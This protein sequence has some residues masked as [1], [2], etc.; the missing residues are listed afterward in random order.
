MHRV[1]TCPLADADAPLRVHFVVHHHRDRAAGASGATLSL[2]AAL[3]GRG[4]TVSYY[5]HDDAYGSAIS[6]ELS[7]M[8]R[9]PWYVARHLARSSS[10]YDVIDATTG[11]AWLWALLGRRGGSHA[12]L[13]TR[14]HGLEHVTTEDLQRRARAREFTLSRRYPVY[15]GGYRLWEVRQ[16]LRHSDAQI[17]LNE[18]DREYAV[19]RLGVATETTTVL[20]NG[21][22]DLFLDLPP[23]RPAST[24]SP[25]ALAFIGSWISRKGV[26]AIVE[27]TTVLLARGVPFTLRFLGTG[28]ETSALRAKFSP[29]LADSITGTSRY[30][31][32][33]LPGLLD[34]AEVLLHPSWTEGFSL[35]LVEGM[36]CGLA[37][38]STR[39]GGAT[40]VVRDGETGV[41]LAN[42]SGAALADAVVRLADDRAHLARMRVAA[43]SSMQALRWDTIAAR[44]LEVYRATIARRSLHQGEAT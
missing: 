38:V 11:D 7:R 13:V 34:G 5:F 26:R 43:Q 32:A 37:P 31:P 44:T 8:V 30:D 24:T 21:V 35:A 9:F 10:A 33:E 6:G 16:S 18:Q 19:Q 15:H 36:A 41:L 22:P 27:M 2:G 20:P 40:T 12:A 25:I 42:E 17:L 14:S 1:S 28:M 39:S 23:V 29:A 3:E 4:S